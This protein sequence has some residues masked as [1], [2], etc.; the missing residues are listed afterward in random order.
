MN[1]F[2][3]RR[4]SRRRVRSHNAIPTTFDDHGSAEQIIPPR[5]A[6]S[7]LEEGNANG[8]EDGIR[9]TREVRVDGHEHEHKQD[10]ITRVDHGGGKGTGEKVFPMGQDTGRYMHSR[11]GSGYNVGASG[12]REWL[13]SLDH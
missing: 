2:N 10:T 7:R 11:G 9:V 6:A 13:G 3:R 8:M 12:G 5:D 4:N 1:T